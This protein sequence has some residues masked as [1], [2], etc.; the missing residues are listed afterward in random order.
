[1]AS[2]GTLARMAPFSSIRAHGKMI[3]TM[4]T[5]NASIRIRPTIL[6]CG[7]TVPEMA[8]AYL[9]MLLVNKK[10]DYGPMITL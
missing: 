2:G 8:K 7:E 9:W 5:V 3:N 10:L 4:V 1:M 6:G